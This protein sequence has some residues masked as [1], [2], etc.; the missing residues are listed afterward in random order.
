[1]LTR[2]TTLAGGLVL[3]LAGTAGSQDA[4]R[5]TPAAAGQHVGETATV[6][7]TVVVGRC[8]PARTT[9]LDLSTLTGGKV[10]V[11]LPPEHRDAFGTRLEAQYESADVCATGTIEQWGNDIRIVVSSPDRLRIERPGAG[12]GEPQNGAFTACD[13]GVTLPQVVRNVRP[14]YSPEA[15][16]ARV[17]GNVTLRGVVAADGTVQAIRVVDS[18]DPRLDRQALAAFEQWTFTPGTRNGEVVPVAVLVE[19]TFTMK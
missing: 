14:V 17:Q 7:G 13:G 5:L 6:C 12:G 3:L 4:P 1:M 11:A 18:L 19:F 10:S 2:T 15:M 8:G 9:L 16:E